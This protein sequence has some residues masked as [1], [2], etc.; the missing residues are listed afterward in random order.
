MSL[1]L[2]PA[3]V[4]PLQHDVFSR[5]GIQV[6]VLRLDL[7]HPEVSGNK[8]FKLKHNINEM[9]RQNK[10]TLLTFGGAYS[11]HIAATAAAGKA[12]GFNTIGVIRGEEHKPLNATLAKAKENGMQFYYVSRKDYGSKTDAGLLVRLKE[13]F[14]D[15]YLVPEGGSNELGVKGCQEILEH[16]NEDFDMVCCAAGTGATLAGIALSLKENQK[17]IGIAVLKGAAFLNEEVKRFTSNSIHHFEMITDYHFGGYAKT[18]PALLNFI[19]DF[20]RS[21]DVP[22]DQVYTGKAMFGLL[23]MIRNG[24]IKKGQKVLF[25]HS[26]GL[27]GRNF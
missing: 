25:I 19:L 16:V 26:G 27:Q 11:N 10:N 15:F 8:W 23:D 6:M 1:Q 3:I 12:M 21:Q 4:Q 18:S 13:K 9:R 22:L 17:A 24:R 20:E 2:S 14:G 5:A 7:I